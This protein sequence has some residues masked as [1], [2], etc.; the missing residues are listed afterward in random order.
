MIVLGMFFFI[1][2][3]VNSSETIKYYVSK[4][5]DDENEGT[6][7]APFKT[8]TKAKRSV[9]ERRKSTDSEVEII[10]SEGTYYLDTP[11]VFK[12]EESGKKDSPYIIRSKRD[13]HV[14]ISGGKPLKDL[15]WEK[16]EGNIWRA[17]VKSIDSVFSLYTENRRLIPARYP[18]F[19]EGIYPYGG[20]AKDALSSDRIASWSNPEGGIIHAMHEGRWGGMHYRI[21]GKNNQDSLEYKGGWQNNRSSS[22]HPKYRYVDHVFEELDAPNEWYFNKKEKALYYYTEH[23][24][25]LEN[26][27][28]IAG[29]L[30]SIVQFQGSEKHPVENIQ[31]SD[32]T[33]AHT[34]PTYM[35]TKEP[36]M[37][38]DWAI[39]RNGAVKLKGTKGI[40]VENNNF[41]LLGG[42]AIFV[43]GF[44]E[45]SLIKGNLIEDVGASA[46]AFVG[47]PDAVRSPS[48]QYNDYVKAKN[49][50]T[51]A[52]SKTENY[53]VDGVVED[54]LIRNI[55]LIEKQVAGIQ[56][57]MASNIVASHNTIY[58]VPRAGINIGDGAWGGH[59]LEQ[60]D[61]FE[62]VLET[63]DHGALNSWGRDRFWHP[64]RK[65]MDSLVAVHPDWILLDAKETTIIRNNRF[66]CDH[67][68]DIDLDDG[69][70]NYEIYNNLLLNGGIKLREGF[71]RKV[72]NNIV[73]NN[74]FHPHVWFEN[75]GDIF[76][77]NLLMMAH[78]PIA[79]DYWGDKV[80]GNIFTNKEDLMES[81]KMQVDSNSIW[82]KPDFKNP[83]KGDFRLNNEVLEKLAF[84]N[85]DFSSVGVKS[86]RLKKITDSPEI[87]E[88]LIN[89]KADRNG[90]EEE[91]KW[92]DATLKPMKTKGEQS[93]TGLHEIKG[94]LVVEL[95]E[96]SFLKK[97]GLQENDVI[98]SCFDKEVNDPMD[99]KKI[100]KAN[101][102]KG[103]VELI[104]WRN[105]RERSLQIP[106]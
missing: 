102:W 65:V 40:E 105:Q 71:K 24:D 44:N 79:M 94:V 89:S 72:Y 48:F 47:S 10:L 1:Q 106:L 18:N 91:V 90:S 39:Y 41:Q 62:T 34:S 21:T 33:F 73:I 60:N 9:K 23:P 80:D 84:E 75:S 103:Q 15:L 51:T 63:G 28:F 31:F 29:N 77:N 11:L 86:E 70:T 69:A 17:K 83:E 16:F 101:K 35:K 36:L 8:I 87:P 42:N 49:M 76:K 19:K 88:L 98:L 22:M 56:I 81:Q 66:R 96:N 5:G 68:W 13:D 3:D 58:Q 26:M 46:I 4:E 2:C 52:G 32:I 45:N 43:D 92:Y 64:D 54:N 59:I 57:Q 97:G 85:V 30:E 14:T 12:P 20:F 27:S 74:G 38:S 61:V 82:I 7:D 6:K 99:L 25:S 100:E 53:P 67:G 95:N 37:R 93:A 104:I 50:D 55:G 78:Q